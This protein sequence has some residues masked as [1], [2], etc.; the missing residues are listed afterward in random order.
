M[1]IQR[2]LQ[3]R[4]VPVLTTEYFMDTEGSRLSVIIF[5]AVIVWH[6][7]I[8]SYIL[9]SVTEEVHFNLILL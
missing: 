5:F 9:S 3:L 7:T 4:S 6:C 2:N 8:G 1:A